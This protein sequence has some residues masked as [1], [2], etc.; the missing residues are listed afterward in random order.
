MT[1]SEREQPVA[2]N[3]D[4]AMIEE[5]AQQPNNGMMSSQIIENPFLMNASNPLARFLSQGNNGTNNHNNGLTPLQNPSMFGSQLMNNNGQN[6]FQCNSPDEIQS[7][8]PF[9]AFKNQQLVGPNSLQHSN[10]NSGFGN[11]G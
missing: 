7:P 2:N 1:I 5:E 8:D 11:L 3:N 9:Y 10:S 4:M 6:D